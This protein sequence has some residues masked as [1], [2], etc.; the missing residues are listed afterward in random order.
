MTV[1]FEC[2]HDDPTVYDEDI[3]IACGE[4]IAALNQVS[5]RHSRLGVE[6]DWD[7]LELCECDEE[8]NPN[9]DEEPTED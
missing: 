4:V 7:E 2:D 5:R 9:E 8:G 6:I 3:D 1:Y